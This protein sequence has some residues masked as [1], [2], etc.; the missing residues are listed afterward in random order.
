M[1]AALKMEEVDGLWNVSTVPEVTHHTP[2]YYPELDE[3]ERYLIDLMIMIKDATKDR[4]DVKLICNRLLS[5][6][7]SIE[8]VDAKQAISR[9]TS[10]KCTNAEAVD[11]MQ[12]FIDY[13]DCRLLH[14]LIQMLNDESLKAAWEKYCRRLEDA[15]RKSL[16]ACKQRKLKDYTPPPNG[17][18]VGLQTMYSASELQIQKMLEVRQFLCTVVGLEESAFQGFACS[19]LTLFFAVMRAH[20]PF[21]LCKFTRHRRALEDIGIVVVFVPGEFIY[22][23]QLDRE[24]PFSQ[25]GYISNRNSCVGIIIFR[26]EISVLLTE[27][28]YI[29]AHAN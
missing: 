29:V 19:V 8:K 15:C 3:M 7:Q 26:C 12:Q 22:D 2:L 17:L 6:L 27:T 9:L 13:L 16:N 5:S 21:L 1:Y 18:I 20:L 14:K 23:V 28:C 24:H 25:V 4:E 10:T 11:L